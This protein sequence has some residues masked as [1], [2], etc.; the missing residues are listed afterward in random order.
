ML[1]F[2]IRDTYTATLTSQRAAVRNDQVSFFKD[3]TYLLSLFVQRK[4]MCCIQQY[5]FIQ[6]ITPIFKNRFYI[7]S[8]DRLI[9]FIMRR[10]DQACFFKGCCLLQRIHIHTIPFIP[11]VK[12]IYISDQIQR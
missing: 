7:F 8:H 3:V 6:Y 12:I 4:S 1:F 2:H 9:L 5:I 11:T 10:Q